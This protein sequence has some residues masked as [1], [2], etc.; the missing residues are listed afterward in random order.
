MRIVESLNQVQIRLRGL[1]G[2]PATVELTAFGHT[3]NDGTE[4][5]LFTGLYVHRASPQHPRF[6]AQLQATLKCDSGIH[7]VR[8]SV[9][10]AYIRE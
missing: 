5:W 10:C 1:D 8:P 3:H 6:E 7:L 4:L 9:R 2:V